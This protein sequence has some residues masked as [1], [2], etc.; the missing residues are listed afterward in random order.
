MAKKCLFLTNKLEPPKIKNQLTFE[1]WH[2]TARANNVQLG[3]AVVGGAEAS[4]RRHGDRV[5]AGA[6]SGGRSSW[7]RDK[8][9]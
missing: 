4:G 8:R 5:G 7:Q 9:R 6:Q 3:G 1:I 2:A